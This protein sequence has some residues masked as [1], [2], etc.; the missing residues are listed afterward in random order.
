MFWESL[1]KEFVAKEKLEIVL[2]APIRGE[3]GGRGS[4]GIPPAE[5]SNLGSEIF[6]QTP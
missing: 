2:S 5:P 3:A 4:G 6:K 1:T